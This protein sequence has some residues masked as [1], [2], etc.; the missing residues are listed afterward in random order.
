MGF[1]FVYCFDYNMERLVENW[2][3]AFGHKVVA[4]QNTV[5]CEDM[6]RLLLQQSGEPMVPANHSVGTISGTCEDVRDGNFISHV[7]KQ[8]AC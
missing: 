4:V 8:K 1:Y 6:R 3:V 5:D 2:I 7:D